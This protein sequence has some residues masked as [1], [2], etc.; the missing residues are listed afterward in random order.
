VNSELKIDT[1]TQQAGDD[2]SRR[3]NDSFVPY[4]FCLIVA[5]GMS[6]AGWKLWQVRQ[7]ELTRGEAIPANAIGP[8]LKEFELTERS[9]RP[10]RSADM[11]GRVWVATY[12]FTSCP[13]QCLRL[14]ANLRVLNNMP[15]LKDVT[16]VSISCDPDTDTLEA[17]RAYAD[18]FQADPKRWL[19]CRADLDYIKRVAKG[20]G[21][22]L[23][24][25]G[26]QDFAIVMDKQGKIR[27][28]F[29][30]TSES[31]CHRL[32]DKLLE[33]LAEKAPSDL[34]KTGTANGKSS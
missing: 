22:Y 12:F 11:R 2:T 7:F 24:L 29:D 25:K 19:F 4:V 15:D 9:G 14:N 28:V 21:V 33:C 20:M 27:G 8:P 5:L 18:R 23:S 3:G 16:W 32:H 34:V 1:P 26:H 13:G 31:Q 10:F 17:L 6:Y 30:A